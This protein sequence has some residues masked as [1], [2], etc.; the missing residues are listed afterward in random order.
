MNIQTASPLYIHELGQRSNQ[1]DSLWPP[2]GKASQTDR[3]FI[4][5]DG[6]GGH[7]HGEVASRVVTETVGKYLTEHF[8]AD[9]ALPDDV[10][11]EAISAAYDQLDAIDTDTRGRIMG[12]TLTLLCLHRGG[13]TMAHIGDSRIYHIRTE[14]GHECLLYLSRDHSLAM[15]MYLAGE[16]SQEEMATYDKK[17]IITRAMQPH[18]ERHSRPD[19]V[20]TTDLRGGDYFFLCTDGITERLS[21]TELLSILCAGTTD[22]E[23]LQK[24][25]EATKD[26]ADNHTAYLVRIEDAEKDTS[27]AYAQHNED[28]S[29]AN[30]L[31]AKRY[32]LDDEEYNTGNAIKEICTK[33]KNDCPQNEKSWI[34][35]FM[36]IW[37]N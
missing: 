4:V 33:D 17:N 14:K 29:R 35:R 2:F 5:C 6:M 9:S 32:A 37:M 11:M 31:V 7:E 30:F 20:H 3:V 22:K 18:Q 10:I 24:I 19:I 34:K 28:T 27:D 23:K 26:A 12:T 8:P 15:E 36:K 13:A 1:E 25:K 16:L 21:D